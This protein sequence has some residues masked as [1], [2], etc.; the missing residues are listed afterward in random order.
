[1]SASPAPTPYEEVLRLGRE[2]PAPLDDPVPGMADRAAAHRRRDPALPA[3]QRRPQHDLHADRAARGDGPHLLGLA[4]RPASGATTTG[5][6]VLR[7]RIVEE[8][9]PLRA[10]V[11]KGFDDWHGADVVAGHRLG[12]RLPRRCCCPAAA[13]APTSSRT[14]SRSSSPPRSSRVWAARTYELGLYGIAASRWLRDL[15]RA[16]YGQ[17][18]SWFRLGVDHGIYRPAAG[19]ATPRHRHLLRAR[20]HRRAAPCRS[21]LLALEELHR[22]RPQTRFVLFGQAERARPAVRVRAARRGQP[23]ACSRGATRRPPSGCAC[24]SRTTR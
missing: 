3:R 16:R 24:R 9:A 1:M 4:V 7:R 10:P 17:R 19:G 14:T 11:H 8:F 2:G 23:R 6:A 15:L 22:R 12:H 13:P 20:V 5:A 18:G 21:A